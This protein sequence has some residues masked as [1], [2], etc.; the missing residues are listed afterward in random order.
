V[1]DF[2]RARAGELLARLEGEVVRVASAEPAPDAVHD[3]RV[4][5][6]RFGRCLRAFAEFYPRPGRKKVRRKLSGLMDLAAGVRDR[7]IAL[8]LIGQ[9]GVAPDSPAMERL[10]RRRARDWARLQT[11]AKRWIERAFAAKWREGLEL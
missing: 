7:D 4:S 3:L 8:E 2:A 1:K 6:R 11:T 5:I 10:R 9:A